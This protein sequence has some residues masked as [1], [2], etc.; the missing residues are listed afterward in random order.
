MNSPFKVGPGSCEL[1]L[2]TR[3][4]SFHLYQGDV[5]LQ[6]SRE[7][8]VKDYDDTRPISAAKLVDL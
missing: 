5:I 3:F 8:P 7:L 2:E 4:V 6:A 1:A